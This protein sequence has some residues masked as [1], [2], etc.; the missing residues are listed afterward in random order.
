[1]ESVPRVNVLLAADVMRNTEMA[2][3]LITTMATS[4]SANV[5]ALLCRL[6][7]RHNITRLPPRPRPPQWDP[8]ARI[9]NIACHRA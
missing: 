7:R 4:S 5:K 8:W 3:M 2:S 1:M 9:C 6:N